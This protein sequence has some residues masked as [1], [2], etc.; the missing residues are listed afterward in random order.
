MLNSQQYW[1]EAFFSS[2]LFHQVQTSGIFSDSKTFADA[3]PNS[4]FEHILSLYEQSHSDADFDL[5]A[6]VSE[7]FAIRKLEELTSSEQHEH[8]EQQIC[9]LW[10]VLKKAPDSEQKGSLIPLHKPYTVPG[11]RFQEV[12]YWDSYFAALG[13]IRAGRISDV[14]D[15]VENFI[16]VQQR[17]G[18]IPNGN[19]WYYKSR[20]QPPVL[21]LI[22]DLLQ[23]N[24]ACTEQEL[25]RFRAAIAVEYEF[26]MAGAKDVSDQQASQRAV[27]LKDGEIL[28]RYFDPEP[29]PRPESYAEDMELAASLPEQQKADFYRNIRAACESGWDFSSRWF[30][31][32]KSLST[33]ATTEIIPV[34]LNAIL[35]FVESWLANSYGQDKPEQAQYYQRAAAARKN[36]IDKYLWNAQA[37][38]HTDY[39][40][41]TDEQSQVKTL[42]TVWTLFFDLASE[43]QAK[44]IAEQL[45]TEFLKAGGLITTLNSTEQQW[46]APNGWAPLHWIAIEGLKRHQFD[47]LADTV[48]QRWLNTVTDTYQSIGKLM[49][50][51]NVVN[52][53]NKA[54]GGEYDVQEGFGWTNGVTLA[55]LQG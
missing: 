14:I 16:S 31:D 30:K 13:L 40:F 33:I 12:Y 52:T 25:K 37:Q 5:K 46:D 19:R 22:V 23:T 10:S 2:D 18:C 27:R 3:E 47:E 34:D 24:N 48:A 49:E 6:F 55:L 50:K 35:Y 41:L 51:Y 1:I 11:G 28:N 21:A 32:V 36:A 15:L 7:H 54:D 20:T 8:L 42:A 53:Q 29:T 17:V 9:H 45:E 38:V 26:W 39:W 44:L 4:S 43:S